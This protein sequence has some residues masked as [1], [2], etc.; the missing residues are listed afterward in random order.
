MRQRRSGFTLIEMLVVIAIIGILAALILPA[1]QRAREAARRTQCANN[2]R[3]LALAVTQFEGQKQY[4][5]NSGSYGVIASGSGQFALN[6]DEPKRS[7]VVDLLPFIERQDIQDAWRFDDD[8][9]IA[10]F[11][12]HPNW[13]FASPATS[14]TDTVDGIVGVALSA[15]EID[16][17][18]L[19]N[20][21][22]SHKYLAILVCPND[23]TSLNQG[24]GLTYVVNSG[25]GEFDGQPATLLT[26]TWSRTL[27]DW[28]GDGN[29]NGP[30]NPLFD[31]QD[32]QIAR[33]MGLFWP[34]AAGKQKT[35][36]D[37]RVTFA[38]ILDGTSNTIMFAENTNAGLLFSGDPNAVHG[39]FTW[40]FPWTTATGFVIST[41]DICP[42]GPGGVCNDPQANLAYQNANGPSSLVG[43]INKDVGSNEG[44]APFASS[45]H[46]QVI[47]VVMCDSSTRS[48]ATDV[49]GAVFCKLVSPQGS[50][51]Q[52]GGEL[53]SPY[54]VAGSALWQAPLSES[55]F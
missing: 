39:D 2:M 27:I 23:Q 13:N 33:K 36:E 55:D 21:A 38:S 53:P 40:A 19:D 45:Y 1:V 11:Q 14:P 17:E 16:P 5:P 41:Y 32:A 24:G 31:P 43:R 4:L 20:A 22:L 30:F 44:R 7:W 42:N 49:D 37:V 54:P 3:Q 47:N 34:G 51:L 12:D 8:P 35:A 26:H 48:L 25:Y 10:G 15:G 9:T 46:G 52:K 29:T 6:F 28:D 18:N 50:K